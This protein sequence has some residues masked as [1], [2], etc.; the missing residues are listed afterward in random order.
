MQNQNS[1]S[2]QEGNSKQPKDGASGTQPQTGTQSQASQNTID[3]AVLDAAV[4]KKIAELEAARAEKAAAAEAELKAKAKEAVE[5]FVV[6]HKEEKY[7]IPGTEKNN[8]VVRHS[9]EE[10]T[11]SGSVIEDPGSVRIQFYRPEVYNEMIR[12]NEKTG[13]KNAFLE[14]GEKAIVLHDPTK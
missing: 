1:Q 9:R 5:P 3:P 13:K 4:E 14:M 2:S 6:K 7:K 11:T 10:K 8:Y 12:E